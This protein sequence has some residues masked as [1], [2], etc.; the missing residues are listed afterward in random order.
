MLTAA[1]KR[2]RASKHHPN[3][4]GVQIVQIGDDPDAPEALKQLM[5]GDVGV[6]FVC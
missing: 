5:Y 6:R 3:S 1:V 2:M 4:V